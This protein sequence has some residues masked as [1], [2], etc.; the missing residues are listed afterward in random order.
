MQVQ[1][2]GACINYAQCTHEKM[3]H[4]NSVMCVGRGTKF[5]EFPYNVTSFLP[6]LMSLYLLTITKFTSVVNGANN[7]L[8]R[9][10]IVF[11]WF[12]ARV[13][14]Y[15]QRICSLLIEVSQVAICRSICYNIIAAIW[16]TC[17]EKICTIS[18]IRNMPRKRTR[19]NQF[20]QFTG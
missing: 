3:R 7:F 4:G 15:A 20:Q 17:Q 12:I 6:E 19:E 16:A 11:T 13:A 18:G 5:H 2:Y 14:S 9:Y 8:N 10:F 1:K